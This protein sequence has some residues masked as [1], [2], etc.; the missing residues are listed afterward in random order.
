MPD[1]VTPGQQAFTR[2]WR[3]LAVRIAVFALAAV[4][5]AG[6]YAPFVA[7]EIALLWRDAKGVQLP[8]F[9]DLFNR[10]SY[11][12][13]NDLLFNLLALLLPLLLL[14]GWGLR[15]RLGALR[16][17]GCGIAVV[18]AAW[19]VAMLPVLPAAKGWSAAWDYRPLSQCTSVS[20][21]DLGAGGQPPR[22]FFAPIPHRS[23]ATYHDAALLPPLAIN[24]S[25]GARF[26]LG[27]DTNGRDVLACLF[28]GA[29]I[30]LTIG[31][32]AT[33][34]SLFIGVIVGAASGYFGGKVD[35]LL[36]R[37]VEMML[38]I[39]TFNIIL[40]VIAMTG[41][42]IFIIM[43]VI[44][45][46]GWAGTARLVRGEFL[47]QSV[48]DYVTAAEAIGVP[49]WRIMFRH[50]LP[51]AMAPIIITAT[52]GIAG[53]VLGESGLSFLGLG[54]P[55]TASWGYL[56]DEGRENIRYPWLIYA[57]GVAIFVLVTCLNLI[58]NGLRDAFDPKST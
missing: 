23:D 1:A 43:L 19:L 36:Q 54:D 35:F 21:H 2:F 4:V 44:G 12:H 27:T 10:T 32:V 33:G 38:C 31:F 30:S 46:F 24:P 49:R 29:R 50:I 28:F 18:L 8:F 37:V 3:H 58:G 53:A 57:P 52:F 51:N 20:A 42:N 47:A 13:V 6:I 48:R 41:P 5:L 14:G 25:T 17:I 15:R 55:T 45:L 40:F 34:I 22:A 16:L 11:P 56:L 39:P 26:W 7:S 9:A